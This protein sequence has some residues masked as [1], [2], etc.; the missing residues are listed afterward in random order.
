M[1]RISLVQLGSLAWISFLESIRHRALLG[2][3]LTSLG[4]IGF[5]MVLSALAVR[6]EGVRVVID[7]GLMC[8]SLL[9]VI[10][11]IIL[12]VIL[13]HKEIA[14]RTIYSVLSKPV[15]RPIFVL[16]KYAGL[17]G[18]LLATLAVLSLAWFGVLMARG[19][20][21]GLPHVA[22]ALLV[23]VEVWLITSIAVF[24]STFA[25]PV[26]SGIFAFGIFLIGRNVPIIEHLLRRK[27]GFFAE[28]PWLRPFGE[29]LVA[30]F[31]DLTTFQVSDH[32]LHGMDVPW[33]YVGA[34]VGYAASYIV[35][36][37][38]LGMLLFQRRD[39]I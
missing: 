24:F 29:G 2:L 1:I 7:F 39:F 31:P 3:L 27:G 16:G 21:P 5:S 6:D 14:R 12:G 33:P 30:V 18:M 19:G 25:T 36:F 23:L 8:I 10:T 20:V 11:A 37:L 32:L 22:A 38:C 34:S 4:F 35:L 15:P 26:L 9:G 28:N 17:C 13:V